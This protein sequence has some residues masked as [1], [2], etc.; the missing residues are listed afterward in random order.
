MENTNDFWG[1]E[2]PKT[3]IEQYGSPLYVYNEKILRKRCRELKSLIDYPDFVVDYSMKANPNPALLK[4]LHEEGVEIDVVSAGEIY[5]AELAG[6]TPE[7]L[8]FVCNNICAEE[9]KYALD[10]GIR[11]SVDSLSQLEQFG[12]ISPHS[13]VAIRV[14]PG[15]GAG[16]HSK[17]I[18]AGKATKF[19]INSNMVKE[20]KEICDKYDLTISGINQHIGSLFLKDENFLE[21]I[22]LLFDFCH[23]FADLDFIDFGGG[24]GI[25]Y[26]A[27]EDRLDLKNLGKTLNKYIQQFISDYGKKI[28]I[29]IEPGR[30]IVAET[31]S[32]L[33]TV[34]SKKENNSIQYIGTDLGFNVLMR[35]ILYNS[36]HEINVYRNGIEVSG[37]EKED[38]TIVGNICESGD[39]LA[40]NRTLP[41]LHLSDTIC[42]R[43]T[44]A[45]GQSMSSNYNS[46]LRPAEVMI[47]STGNSKLI[48]KRD[49]FE[50]LVENYVL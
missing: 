48:R 21:S 7:E 20:I 9:M 2:T 44:G 8:F 3:L 16:H 29:R 11:I 25:P 42:V 26:R 35:P 47:T 41:Q 27:G 10:K 49:S 24:F 19:G 31:C 39:I 5:I 45:Y 23:N 12:K 38:V 28:Q 14:N 36:Y 34:F 40:H 6:F 15:V 22:H 18:T 46:R 13:K 30:Y 50:N 32:L 1:I 4:I 33:G 43:D 17:V 37:S